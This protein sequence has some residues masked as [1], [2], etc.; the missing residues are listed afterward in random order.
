MIVDVLEPCAL[1]VKSLSAN[2]ANL[3]YADFKFTELMKC[4]ESICIKY[5]N[6]SIISALIWN[7]EDRFLQRRTRMTDILIFLCRNGLDTTQFRYYTEPKMAELKSLLTSLYG[8][9]D[10]DLIGNSFIINFKN[11]F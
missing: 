5:N 11:L 10:Y 8:E 7:L 1:T 2:N 9:M 6:H 4:L 3:V